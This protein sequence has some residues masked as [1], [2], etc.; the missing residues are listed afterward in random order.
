MGLTQGILTMR[1]TELKYV[2]L[3]TIFT[4]LFMLV[5]KEKPTD[6]TGLFFV[7]ILNIFLFYSR[8]QKELSTKEVF[9]NYWNSRESLIKFKDFVMNYL[10]TNLCVVDSKSKI[11]FCNKNFNATFWYETTDEENTLSCLNSLTLDTSESSLD[12][13][14]VV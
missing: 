9:E 10:P 2:T 5:G 8:L 14:S 11:L 4:S 3:F 1:M 13:K 7:I 12:R 6:I